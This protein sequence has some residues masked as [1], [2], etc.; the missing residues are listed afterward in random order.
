MVV[1]WPFFL[2]SF[3]IILFSFDI[4]AH[5]FIIF[6]FFLFCAGHVELQYHRSIRGAYLYSSSSFAYNSIHGEDEEEL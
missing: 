3:F 5:F 6:F 4:V 1:P 2:F